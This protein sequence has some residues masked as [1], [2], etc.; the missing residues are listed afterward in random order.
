M[1]YPA[2]YKIKELRTRTNTYIRTP[3]R[4][5]EPIFTI[6]GQP[7]GIEQ[8]RR[9]ILED[10]QHFTDIRANKHR[11]SLSSTTISPLPAGHEELFQP[12]KKKY[13]GM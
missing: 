7:E 10:S 6:T 12:V 9:K 2:G 13:V 1:C 4:G 3:Q 11:S 8:A 5:E